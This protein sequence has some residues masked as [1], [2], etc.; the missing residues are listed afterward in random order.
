MMANNGQYFVR[1]SMPRPFQSLCSLM[2]QGHYH[3]GHRTWS[4]STDC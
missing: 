3:Q 1:L 4:E 2:Q